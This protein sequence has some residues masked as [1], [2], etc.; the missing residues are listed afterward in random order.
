MLSNLPRVDSNE[1]VSANSVATSRKCRPRIE[2]EAVSRNGGFSILL[3]PVSRMGVPEDRTQ[4]SGRDR[5]RRRAAGIYGTIVTAAVIAA[6]GNQLTTTELEVTVLVTL[7]VYWLAEQYAELLGEHTHAGRLPQRD[8]VVSSLTA[9]WP[10]VSA[11]FIPLLSLLL[12]RLAGGSAGEAAAAALLVTVVLLVVHG[13]TA[14]R[15]ARLTGFRMLL[16]T[17]TAGL[18]GVAMVVLKTLL[19]NAHP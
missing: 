3:A 16:V 11:S 7:I 15:A 17:A 2:N 10:M 19:Q 14:A 4:Q 12:A 13:Y 5:G 6:G 1:A 8:Q 18:L 9:A